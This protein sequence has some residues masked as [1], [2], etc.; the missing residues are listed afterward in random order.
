M[1]NYQAVNLLIS[2][3]KW[4]GARHQIDIFMNRTFKGYKPKNFFL[5]HSKVV[6]GMVLLIYW[7]AALN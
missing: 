6:A 1:I 5:I 4:C 2:F 3:G 7:S